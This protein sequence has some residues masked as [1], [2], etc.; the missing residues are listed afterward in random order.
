M[1]DEEVREALIVAFVQGARWWEFAKTGATMWQSDQADAFDEAV[2]RA[3]G[4]RLGVSREK[5]RAAREIAR[6][7]E[8]KR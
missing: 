7:Q 5:Q 1:T 6:A 2:V 3:D 8:G 4:G